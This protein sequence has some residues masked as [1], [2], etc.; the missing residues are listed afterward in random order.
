MMSPFS[1]KELEDVNLPG[2][3]Q[4]SQGFR[5]PCQSIEGCHYGGKRGSMRSFFLPTIQH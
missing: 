1:E 3:G 2:G 4:L 5:T